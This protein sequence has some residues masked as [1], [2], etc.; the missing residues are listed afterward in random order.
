MATER[1][2]TRYDIKET[3]HEFQEGGKVWLWNPVRLKGLF[4]Q[5]AIQ[6]GWSAH[7]PQN[8]ERPRGSYKEI[9]FLKTEGKYILIG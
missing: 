6:L 4:S 1:M 9:T 5:V 3:N 7:S 8:T 2:K